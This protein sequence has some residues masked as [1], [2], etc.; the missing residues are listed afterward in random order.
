MMNYHFFQYKAAVLLLNTTLSKQLQKGFIHPVRRIANLVAVDDCRCTIHVIDR[1][2]SIEEIEAII[3]YSEDLV[4]RLIKSGR[5]D[6]LDELVKAFIDLGL[7]PKSNNGD[8]V[9]G[10]EGRFF[11]T[12]YTYH[13]MGGRWDLCKNIDKA[14]NELS[15]FD[16]E[17]VDGLLFILDIRNKTIVK[18]YIKTNSEAFRLLDL[19]IDRNILH[20][21]DTSIRLFDVD[22]PKLVRLHYAINMRL[23]DSVKSLCRL[24]KMEVCK[25]V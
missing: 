19:D 13:Y 7:M 1:D 21:S 12:I 16:K 14:Y 11:Q 22:D 10:Y 3:D 15:K 6:M 17:V 4:K 5:I 9:D 8:W 25:N 20:I 23:D 2:T 18:S 24:I